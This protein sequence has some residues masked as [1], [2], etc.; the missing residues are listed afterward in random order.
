MEISDRIKK[1]TCNEILRIR[2]LVRNQQYKIGEVIR[3]QIFPFTWMSPIV[4][5]GESYVGYNRLLGEITKEFRD[6]PT[7]EIAPKLSSLL[8]NNL[9]SSATDLQEAVDKFFAEFKKVEL[10]EWTIYVP[11]RAEINEDL[12]IGQITIHPPN[13]DAWNFMRENSLSFFRVIYESVRRKPFIE[14][15]IDEVT[16]GRAI[17]VA[18][19]EIENHLNFM[20]LCT[21]EI[22]EIIPDFFVLQ[23]HQVHDIQSSTPGFPRLSLASRESREA[24]KRIMTT[25]EFLIPL[26]ER[27]DDLVEIEKRVKKAINWFGR[28]QNEG[29]DLIK[30]LDYVIAAEILTVGS[31]RLNSK[32]KKD[33]ISFHFKKVIGTVVK[34]LNSDYLEIERQ[35]KQIYKKR[36]EI[37]HTGLTEVTLED[38]RRIENFSIVL[39]WF[40]GNS[41]SNC[42]SGFSNSHL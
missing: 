14:I 19:K 27:R 21:P 17:R 9:E 25:F 22:I 6:I 16:A 26:L 30:F 42:V 34:H 28:G 12:E 41:W 18:K 38:I 31:R 1:M 40:F 29:D 2:K 13:D 33:N 7:E 11:L 15:K 20:R 23:D 5:Y 36:S 8:L 4:L 35:A 24:F 3:N 37:V 10:I 32:F 39:I